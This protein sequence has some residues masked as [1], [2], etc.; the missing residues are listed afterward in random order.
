MKLVEIHLSNLYGH[1][2]TTIELD[3]VD[4]AAITGPNGAGKSTAFVYGPLFALFGG[5]ARLGD[6]YDDVVRGNAESAT[7]RIDFRL[8]GE[9]YRVRR[10]YSRRTKS[11]KSSLEFYRHDGDDWT[12]VHDG[13]IREV[14]SAIEQTIGIDYDTFTTGSIQ[15]QGDADRFCSATSSERI[16]FLAELLNVDHLSECF[17]EAGRKRD[18][19]EDE[20]ERIEQEIERLAEKSDQLDDVRESIEDVEKQL[21]DL[22]EPEDTDDAEQRLSDARERLSDA[23]DDLEDALERKEEADEKR[24][25]LS[26]LKSR[27]ATLETRAESLAERIDEYDVDV[28]PEAWDKPDLDDER[29]DVVERIDDV[30]ETVEQAKDADVEYEQLLDRRSQLELGIENAE[31][32]IEQHESLVEK[33][34]S[35]IDELL[36]DIST[37][38]TLDEYT[39]DAVSD[40]ES[41]LGEK[42]EPYEERVDELKQKADDAHDHLTSVNKD[43]ESI[44]ETIEHLEKQTAAI[45]DRND[46]VDESKCRDCGLLANAFD[47]RDKLED[48][49]EKHEQ[50]VA[51]ADKAR[52]TFDKLKEKTHE[53]ESKRKEVATAV[54]QDRE[55]LRDVYR[56]AQKL[57]THRRGVDDV[58]TKLEN[59]TEELEEVESKIAE[60]RE[61]WDL[62]DE[63]TPT[64][65]VDD[66]LDALKS[67]HNALEKAGEW[68]EVKSDLDGIESDID[69]L[70]SEIEQIED[71][72]DYAGAKKAVEEA[73]ST[74]EKREDQLESLREKNEKIREQRS[75]MREKR[76]GLESQ[77]EQLESE[78]ERLDDLREERD[79]HRETAQLAAYSRRFFDV[80]PQI[81]IGQ[82]IP[83]IEAEANNVL[84]DVFPGVQV[85]VRRQKQQKSGSVSDK[86]HLRVLRNGAEQAYSTFSGG[87]QFLI[88]LAVR[89]GLA[90]AAAERSAGN[91]IDL[92]VIDE[93]FGALDPGNVERAKSALVAL[94]ERFEQ[95]LVISHVPE[96]RHTFGQTIQ[97]QP[98]QDG[99]TDVE[100]V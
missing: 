70:E 19:A 22:G 5:K 28:D 12:P 41:A 21:D 80:A 45:D 65:T 81:V 64:D 60:I 14:E 86:L 71:D 36:A 59:A 68:H 44:A 52:E 100:I 39:T 4:A 35:D 93:G 61:T 76:A 79:E 72:V 10:V 30:E 37:D 78:V 6:T 74:V 8:D 66:E 91:P 56:S 97:V 47:A 15:T 88:S 3:D 29:L 13:S 69:E 75:K 17:T 57:E 50:K 7:A 46:E 27:L 53:A 62:D 98:Q 51:E 32:R 43:V 49:R 63:Q 73:E 96:L 87:E 20:V 34:E 89:M 40:A 58:E 94:T 16:D 23:R 84:G 1:R 38:V 82:A 83:R 26:A 25:K 95:I 48:A 9:A 24:E 11:G 42:V 77:R 90:K 18:R 2:E 33:H 85:E 31:E 99:S 67:R 54:E 92:L 55:I